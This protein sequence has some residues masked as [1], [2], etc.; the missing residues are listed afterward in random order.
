MGG[1]GPL[2]GGVTP[3]FLHL[4]HPPIS[5]L[6]LVYTLLSL[7]PVWAAYGWPAVAIALAAVWLTSATYSGSAFYIEVRGSDERGGEASSFTPTGGLPPPHRRSSRS[8][9]RRLWRAPP[10]DTPRYARRPQQRPPQPRAHVALELEALGVG[11]GLP[12]PQRTTR[13]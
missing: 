3:L 5:P 1:H 6:Q 2:R 4:L 9:T 11:A 7:V 13:L 12:L 8:A 10:C